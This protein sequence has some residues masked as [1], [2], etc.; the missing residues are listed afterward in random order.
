MR[1]QHTAIAV[2]RAM[3]GKLAT[4]QLDMSLMMFQFIAT[5]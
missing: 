3:Y 1:Q 2:A 5:Y 4:G